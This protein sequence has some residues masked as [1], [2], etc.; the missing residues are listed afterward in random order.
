MKRTEIF[1]LKFNH[2]VYYMK[3][4]NYLYSICV[5]YS[6]FCSLENYEAPQL[7]SMLNSNDLT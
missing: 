3:K 5:H 4:V 6:S 7:A 2:F 1:E